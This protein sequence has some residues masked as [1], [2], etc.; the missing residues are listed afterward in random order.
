MTVTADRYKPNLAIIPL[1]TQELETRTVS[2]QDAP[3][4]M[5]WKVVAKDYPATTL[6]HIKSGQE[7][8]V[9]LTL[10]FPL[11]AGRSGDDIQI[12]KQGNHV[13]IKP[14]DGRIFRIT[15]GSAQDRLQIDR[16]N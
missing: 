10:L 6:C 11:K 14:G 16:I 5:G 7:E 1:L 3:E 2:A 15:A 9:F 4:I 13:L 12:E 8:A